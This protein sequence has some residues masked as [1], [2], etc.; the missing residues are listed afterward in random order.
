MGMDSIGAAAR[1]YRRHSLWLTAGLTLAGLV[2][3]A[4][5]PMVDVRFPGLANSLVVSVVYAIVASFA[6]A[7]AWESVAR[8]SAANLAKFYL[9][10]SMLKMLAALAVFLVAAVAMGKPQALTFALVFAA[11]YVALL[12]FDCAFFARIEKKGIFNEN[13]TE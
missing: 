12:V 6:Y 13:K 4:V 1:R 8:G 2:A 5:F 9:V 10:G 11:Y 3:L 7:P